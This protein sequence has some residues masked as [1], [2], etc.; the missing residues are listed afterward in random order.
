MIIILPLLNKLLIYYLKFS[1]KLKSSK[2]NVKIYHMILSGIIFENY[3]IAS[4]RYKNVQNHHAVSAQLILYI[5]ETVHSCHDSIIMC[6]CA[7][8]YTKITQRKLIVILKNNNGGCL[9]SCKYF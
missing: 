4:R 2:K 1:F 9:Q 5:T 8:K 7:T 6:A 3:I